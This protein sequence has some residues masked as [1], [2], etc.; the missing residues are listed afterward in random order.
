MSN[1]ALVSFF[2]PSRQTSTA[3]VALLF[4]RLVMGVAFM[5]HGWQKIKNPTAWV[6]MPNT[7][8]PALFQFLA[9]LSEFGGGAA[10]ILGLLTPLACFGM[11]C[12]MAVAVYVHCAM[13]HHPFIDNTGKGSYELAAVYFAV[14]FLFF[15]VGPGKWSLDRVLF[16]EQK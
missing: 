9:A 4:L 2:R 3:S 7:H 12:T 10:L 5:I 16:G 11:A 6:M 13:F 15:L 14:S 1:S 8:I